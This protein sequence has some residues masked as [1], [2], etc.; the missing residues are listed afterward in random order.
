MVPLPRFWSH[1]LLTL[2]LSLCLLSLL[3]NIQKLWEF[4]KLRSVLFILNHQLLASAWRV[5]G[6]HPLF[7]EDSFVVTRHSLYSCTLPCTGTFIH[8]RSSGHIRL[9]LRCSRW[10]EYIWPAGWWPMG[11]FPPG[12]TEG[13]GAG[14]EQCSLELIGGVEKARYSAGW[15]RAGAHLGSVVKPDGL[16][17]P[18]NIWFPKIIWTCR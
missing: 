6:G 8:L 9:S 5:S 16:T 15:K 18:L 11:Q 12:M 1:T 14:S 7:L 3:W 13:Q 17:S 4:F 10:W 2:S